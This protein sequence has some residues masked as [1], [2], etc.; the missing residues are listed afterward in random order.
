MKALSLLVRKLWPRLKFLSTH[1]RGRRHQGYDISSPDIR[2]GSLKIGVIFVHFFTLRSVIFRILIYVLD[3]NV[4]SVLLF[5]NSGY[6]KT[7]TTKIL[8]LV[9]QKLS[10]L[11]SSIFGRFIRKIATI[12]WFSTCYISKSSTQWYIL[13]FIHKYY[14]ALIYTK[15]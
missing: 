9:L 5:Q 4:T 11:D 14:L 3:G 8:V 10:L 2:P 15:I 12:P 7:N 1:T 6:L 13:L